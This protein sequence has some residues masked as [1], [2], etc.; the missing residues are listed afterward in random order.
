MRYLENN[1]KACTRRGLAASRISVINR[2]EHWLASNATVH[3]DPLVRQAGY[4][5]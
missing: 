3:A 2:L 5:Q 4:E 1:T